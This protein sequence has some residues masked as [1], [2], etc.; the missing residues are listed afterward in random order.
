ML[1]E[2]S[3]APLHGLLW[4][5]VSGVVLSVGGYIVLFPIRTLISSIKTAWAVQTKALTDIQAELVAQRTNCLSTLSSQGESQIE[6]LKET[7]KVLNDMHLD[8]RTLL[9]RLDK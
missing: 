2:A 8:Q 9:G 7:V 4:E 3:Q 6:L 5:A 1:I